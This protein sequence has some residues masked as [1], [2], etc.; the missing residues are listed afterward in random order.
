MIISGRLVSPD[1]VRSG[2]IRIDNGTIVEVGCDLGRPDVEYS[3]D[4]LIFAGMGERIV[5]RHIASDRMIFARGAVK[6]AL[7][8]RSFLAVSGAASAQRR[9]LI[10]DHRFQRQNLGPF[11]HEVVR[12]DRFG[13]A[14]DLL[15]QG[16]NRASQ[17]GG[18]PQKEQ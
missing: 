14:V 17:V 3:D 11:V 2:H 5:L 18:A 9:K 15:L 7:W 4:C 1:Q 12:V 6:A 16:Q 10:A 8:G 13:V